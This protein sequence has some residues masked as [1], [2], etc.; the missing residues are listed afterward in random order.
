MW[1][2]FRQTPAKCPGKITVICIDRFLPEE[3]AEA[4]TGFMKFLKKLWQETQ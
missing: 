2:L 3:V 1:N 4:D